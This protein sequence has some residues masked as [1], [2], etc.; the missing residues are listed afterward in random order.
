MIVGELR[1]RPLLAGLAA[2]GL[3]V[4]GVPANAMATLTLSYDV[5]TGIVGPNDV[6]SMMVTLYNSG[7]ETFEIAG[8]EV[9]QGFSFQ[10]IID[11]G[12]IYQSDPFVE[13]DISFYGFS[14]FRACSGNFTQ[15]NCTSGPYDFDFGTFVNDLILDPGDSYSWEFATF[16]PFG[17]PV[18]NGTYT[19][20]RVGFFLEAYGDLSGGVNPPELFADLSLA[21][22]CNGCTFERT[23]ASVPEPA[24]WAM[25]I[26][27]FGLLG[28]ALRRERMQLALRRG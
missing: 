19:N 18:P 17:G 11:N 13:S 27:G 4:T 26:G 25:M 1:A 3:A 14:R 16:T 12:N 8:G 7:S 10:D 23:V 15:T 28:G 6:V 21:V 9:V 24:S 2:I 22:T 20:T 5:P